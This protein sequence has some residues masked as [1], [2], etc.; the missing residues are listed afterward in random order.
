MLVIASDTWQVSEK[1][2]ADEINAIDRVGGL[3]KQKAGGLYLQ[4]EPAF[5][6]SASG[7]GH[8]LAGG[9]IP[10]APGP[11]TRTSERSLRA[12]TEAA[13]SDVES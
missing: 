5:D 4:Q 2:L 10:T 1:T 3:L 13:I 6:R 11:S 8:R 9:A 12:M 7:R